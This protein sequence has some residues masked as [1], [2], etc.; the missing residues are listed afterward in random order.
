MESPCV[1]VCVI[2]ADTGYCAGCH[3]TIAEIAAWAGMSG[4]QRRKI[5]AGL[6]ERHRS[7]HRGPLT[8]APGKRSSRR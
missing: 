5:M 8:G 6:S 1:N 4:E 3:R 2:E 7:G